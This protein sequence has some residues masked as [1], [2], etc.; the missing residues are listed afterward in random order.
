MHKSSSASDRLQQSSLSRRR[1][2][3]STTIGGVSALA[4]S[5]PS[6]AAMQS[7]TPQAAAIDA[8][9]L[10]SLS[11]RLTGG[12]SLNEAAVP[13]LATLLSAEPDIAATLQELDA[14]SEFSA[15]AL[16]AASP[17]AQAVATNI[18]QYWFLGRYNGEFV[19]N[20]SDI[21]L[22]LACWQALPYSTQPSV[23]KSFGYWAEE[24]AL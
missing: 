17:A 8:A 2:I 4:L 23:C 24:I 7:A 20:R 13:A 3:A 9:D 5:V 19:A 6:L 11:G 12:A 1:L 16:A 18:L 14:I 22:S 15:E 10:F 21:F